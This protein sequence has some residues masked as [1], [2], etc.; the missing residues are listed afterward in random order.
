MKCVGYFKYG[1]VEEKMKGHNRAGGE[2]GG[3]LGRL[4][5]SWTQSSL[6]TN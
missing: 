1:V 6:A 5:P 3:N 4:H 2:R